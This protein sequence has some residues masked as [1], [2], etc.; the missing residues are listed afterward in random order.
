MV[1]TTLLST[2][3]GALCQAVRMADQ[4]SFGMFERQLQLR[5]IQLSFAKAA[6]REVV[7]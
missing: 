5:W 6:R 3:V 1:E 7:T 4:R 2:T